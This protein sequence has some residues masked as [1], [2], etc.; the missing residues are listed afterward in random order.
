[1]NEL[2]CPQC[3][4]DNVQR[5]ELAYMQGSSNI[6]A[7]SNTVGGGIGRGGGS[8]G[9]GVGGAVT[10]TTG[11]SQSLL[12]ESL[13]P[14][15]KAGWGTPI[16]LMLAGFFVLAI[17]LTAWGFLFI[18]FFL[19]GGIALIGGIVRAWQVHKQNKSYPNRLEIW[20]KNWICQRCGNVFI[21]RIQ[22]NQFSVQ[23][24]EAAGYWQ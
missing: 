16:F 19:W 12:A 10:S 7:M 4:T 8:W 22:S 1:M 21:P 17:S 11:T 24:F 15:L 3:A 23:P 14:P 20:R 18:F 13:S 9:A 5:I 2:K 6:Q